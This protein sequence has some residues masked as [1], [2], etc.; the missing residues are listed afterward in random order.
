MTRLTKIRLKNFKSFRSAEIPLS[1]GFTA[2]VGS[3]GSGKSNT[4][5]AILFVLGITSLKTLRASKLVDLINNTCKENY[6]KVDMHIKDKGKDYEVSR[7]ID[8]Q[9]KSVYRINGKRTTLGEVSSLLLELG[10]DVTGHN[11]VTQG[12][13]MKV[14]DM[15]PLQRRQIIDDVAGLSEFDEKKAEALRELEKVDSRIKEATIILNERNTF[16]EELEQEMVAAKEFE[17]LIMEK[18][19][20]KAT[21]IGREVYSL[22]KRTREI[23]TEMKELNKNKDEMEKNIGK[24]REALVEMKKHA[25]TLNKEIIKASEETYSK[26]GKDFEE[27]K[28]Q[29]QL[30]NEKIEMK[31]ELIAKNMEKIDSDTRELKRM[32]AEKTE[33]SEKLKKLDTKYK[34]LLQEIKFVSGKKEGIEDTVL[35]KT[36]KLA[37]EEKQVDALNKEIED[38]R[39]EMFDLEVFVGQWEKQKSFN[40][41]KLVELKREEDSIKKELAEIGE[42][43]GQIKEYSAGKDLEEELQIAEISIEEVLEEMNRSLAIASN[44]QKSI[45]SLRKALSKCPTCDSKLDELGKKRLIEE[46]TKI[47]H[48]METD[49]KNLQQKANKEKENARNL[50]EKLSLITHLQAE[51]AHENEVSERLNVVGKKILE[52][53][54]DLDEKKV[55]EQVNKRNKLSEK[56]KSLIVKR[57]SLKER[58]ETMRSQNIFNEYSELSKKLEQLLHNKGELG[59]ELNEINSRIKENLGPH[60]TALVKEVEEI[61]NETKALKKGIEKKQEDL[62]DLETYV[63]NKEKEIENAKKN[64][65]KL[66]EE[67]EEL[68]KNSDKTEKELIEELSRIK[69]IESRVNEF[70]IEQSKIEVRDDDLRDELKEFEGIEQI[71][72][73]E[74]SELKERLVE[75]DKRINTIGAVNMK[76]VDNFN[77]LKKEVDDIQEKA[78]KLENERLAVLDMID[79]IEFKRTNVFMDCFNEI[80]K[81]FKEMFYNFFG[82]EGMLSMI[83]PENPLESG[84]EIDARHKGDNLQSIDAMSGGEKT[85]TALAF[86]F[87]I[88]L[89]SPAPFYAFDEAD[90]ALDKENSMKMSKLIKMISQNSQFVAIT[91]NDTL[92]KQA[93]QIVGVALNKDKSSVIGLRLKGKEITSL[94]NET[95][96]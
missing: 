3:N 74:V 96:D 30:E 90:A 46:K 57:E 83:D 56:I 61:E 35:E 52:M 7:M 17:S 32:A 26:L 16:L 70:N 13:I 19:Q 47:V 92:T 65:A 6:A 36:G 51:I 9:G 71:A 81:N 78:E 55:E 37:E 84:L 1:N 10:I 41:S 76:A 5:D 45:D 29:L 27:K 95:T 24:M 22:E 79:K 18:R 12:D 62:K 48:K 21:V 85:L 38:T 58:V 4:L 88:Q 66:I 44:E 69:K 11:I 67:K 89:Y 91:H 73:K 59:S 60:E 86:M 49:A 64:N 87:A 94:A 20:L 43:K 31:N 54:H 63:L 8:K 40:E 68:D 82:G 34:E 23:D 80:N 93:D 33:L 72:G 15:N 39:K 75:V 2:I 77:E 14:I 25:A 28:A 50:K 53:K 42:K